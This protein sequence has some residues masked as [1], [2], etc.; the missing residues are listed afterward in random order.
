MRVEPAGARAARLKDMR[1]PLLIVL[2]AL[3]FRA[4]VPLGAQEASALRTRFVRDQTLL[5]LTLYGPAF[6]GAIADDG[7]SALAAYLVMSGGMFFASAELSQHVEITEARQLL[8]TG[9]GARGAGSGALI[10]SQAGAGFRERAAATLVGGLGGTI[11]GL[12]MGTGIEG[13]DAAATLFGHDLLYASA[14]ALTTT[15]DRDL[16]DT[17][18]GAEA[19]AAAAWTAAGWLG[20]GLGRLYA[21]VTPH[22]VTVGDVQTL[23]LGATLGAAAGATAVA[24]GAPEPQTVAMALMGGAFVGTVA[25]ERLFVRRYDLSRSQANLVTVGSGA[26]ALMGLG[27]GLLA[28]GEADRNGAT[29]FA[30]ATAGAA[31]GAVLTARYVGP[32]RDAGRVGA[33]GRL[34]VDPLAAVAAATGRPGP[35]TLVHFTF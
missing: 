10:A 13:G 14:M 1:R 29:T 3:S 4:A 32:A 5:G 7:V 30:F 2:A 9:L 26:G 23:W 25:A 17:K 24:N 33:L 15:S 31:T 11:A 21:G 16:F 34:R 6:A 28:Q 35:H 18:G 19:T 27:I 12:A 22:R 8:A 20:A